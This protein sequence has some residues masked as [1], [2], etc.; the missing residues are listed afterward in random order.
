MSG[1]RAS[2]GLL[3]TGLMLFGPPPSSPDSP[4]VP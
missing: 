1:A 4:G 2:I 3:I